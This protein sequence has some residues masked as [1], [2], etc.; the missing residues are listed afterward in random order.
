[1]S[2]GENL[3]NSR[4]AKG[5]DQ[6]RVAELTG[7]PQSLI[8]KYELDSI[9]PSVTNALKLAKVLDATC[10]QLAMGKVEV[11]D[12]VI[13]NSVLESLSENEKAKLEK[14]WF[15]IQKE[16]KTNGNNNI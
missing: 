6:Y 4:M 1:M 9:I 13:C 15:T 7:I 14:V 5:L 10:E 12:G 16:R 8:S 3:K 2:F 11:L